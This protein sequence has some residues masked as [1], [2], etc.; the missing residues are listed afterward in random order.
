VRFDSIYL[1]WTDD[2]IPG[3]RCDYLE[4]YFQISVRDVTRSFWNSSFYIPLKCGTHEFSDMTGGLYPQLYGPEPYV[5]TIPLAPGEDLSA[6]W[7][8]A[9]FWDSDPPGNPDDLYAT[10]AEH[11]VGAFV[12]QLGERWTG[13]DPTYC[14]ITKYSGGSI[15]DEAESHLTYSFSVYPNTCRDTLPP[16]GFGEP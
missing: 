6:I 14:V 8:K 1:E 12:P 9:K 13:G 5:I 10:F 16:K 15:F 11:P 4:T 2:L 7:I 3:D